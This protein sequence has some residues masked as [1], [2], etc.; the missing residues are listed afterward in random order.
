MVPLI[1]QIGLKKKVPKIDNRSAN[2]RLSSVIEKVILLTGIWSKLIRFQ[3]YMIINFYFEFFYMGRTWNTDGESRE[4]LKMIVN[5][6]IE[7]DET[8]SS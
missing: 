2:Q 3:E 5:W 4:N 8:K 7:S 1:I 6:L